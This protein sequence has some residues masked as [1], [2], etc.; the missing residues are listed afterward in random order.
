MGIREIR[1]EAGLGTGEFKAGDRVLGTGDMTRDGA[2]AER[3]AVDHRVIARI[4]DEL[5]FSDAASLP[6]GSATAW[7]AMF[8]DQGAL[9]NGVDHVMIV[10][11]AGGVG[12]MAIQLLKATTEASI[13]AT[14]S[15][16]ESSGWCYQLGAD[17]VVDHTVDVA[18][19]LA[20]ARIGAGDLLFRV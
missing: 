13:I 9:P 2:W 12:S 17:L 1:L 8:R 14:A 3:V 16:P 7:E 5:G 4:P 18:K 20:E 11:G 10:G 19:A 15:R 6:I